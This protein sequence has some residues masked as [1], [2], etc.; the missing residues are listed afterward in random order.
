MTKVNIV[1]LQNTRRYFESLQMKETKDIDYFMNWFMTA[2]NQ[3]KIY[4]EEIKDQIMVEKVLRYLST[5]FD[6]VVVAIE[7]AKDLA[8]LIID[9]LIES[10]LSNETRIDKNN[11]STLET[12]FKSQ[13]SISRDRVQIRSRSIGRGRGERYGGQKYGQ[14]EHEHESRSNYISFNNNQMFE[15]SNVRCYYCNKFGHYAHNCRENIIDQGNQRANVTTK[16]TISMFLS[17]HT[18]HEPSDNMWLLDNGCSNNMTCNKNLIAN[19]DQ[20]VKT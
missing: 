13:V 18:M 12:A 20:C 4:I 1:K 14:E 7:E 16:S 6:V 15:K 8:P 9:E 3:L 17:F 11:D 5:K 10:L 19:L 2:V